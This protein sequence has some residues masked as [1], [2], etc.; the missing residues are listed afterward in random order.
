M[1]RFVLVLMLAGVLVSCSMSAKMNS[2][3]STSQKSTSPIWTVENIERARLKLVKLALEQS[4][5]FSNRWQ[6]DQRDCAGF[7]RFLYRDAVVGNSEIWLNKELKPAAFVTAKELIAYNFERIEIQGNL[8]DAVAQGQVRSGDVLVFHRPHQ[9][10][11]EDEW[12]L[13]IALQSPFGH[14]KEMIWTY[15][16]GEMGPQGEVRKVS[17]SDL[18]SSPFSEWRPTV[19][20]P[21]FYGIYRWKE[22]L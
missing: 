9:K 7:V 15:H 8:E 22:W 10:R 6:P 14:Q 18:S 21:N 13:M 17:I 16:N 4:E 20:N 11:V 1:L 19:Q 12:H 5:Q 2:S 3:K